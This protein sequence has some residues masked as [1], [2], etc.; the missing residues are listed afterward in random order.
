MTGSLHALSRSRKTRGSWPSEAVSTSRTEPDI[1]SAG[2]PIWVA[3][4]VAPAVDLSIL[5]LLLGT[6]HLNVAD[7]WS[8]ARRSTPW[9]P[10]PDRGCAY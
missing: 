1:P 5:G 6:R 8:Q 10:A 3:P 2:V 9:A 4:L 7:R